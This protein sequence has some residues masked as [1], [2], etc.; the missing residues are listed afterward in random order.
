MSAAI[1]SGA[2]IMTNTPL[3]HLT[4]NLIMNSLML[5][6]AYKNGVKKFVF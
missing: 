3:A 2:K 4:P 5:E 6:A 1:S